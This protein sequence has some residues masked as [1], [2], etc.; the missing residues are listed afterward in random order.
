MVPSCYSFFCEKDNKKKA[1]K[2]R[3]PP[4]PLAPPTPQQFTEW[5]FARTAGLYRHHKAP[6]LT[7]LVFNRERD[8]RMAVT[9]VG[10]YRKQSVPWSTSLSQQSNS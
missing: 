10:A 2:Q 5:P 1:G 3:L 8:N 6:K 7:M 4:Q 9:P